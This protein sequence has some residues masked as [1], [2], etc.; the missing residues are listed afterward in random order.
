MPST[1]II[2]PGF[3][4]RERPIENSSVVSENGLVT[5]TAVFLGNSVQTD[6]FSNPVI[7]SDPIDFS[8]I[9]RPL[10]LARPAANTTDD[11]FFKVNSPI[12]QNYFSSLAGIPLQGLFIE[13][14]TTEKRDGLLYYR[15]SA[16]GAANPPTL[17][18][19]K[20]VSPRSFS[21]SA[22]NRENET[23]T[24]A[25]DY[26]SE[27]ITVST[28][29]V[30]DGEIP[31]P[32]QFPRALE[33]WNIRGDGTIRRRGVTGAALGSEFVGANIQAYPRVLKSTSTTFR[34]GVVQSTKAFQFVYE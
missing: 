6:S 2:R 13:N 7:F 14:I 28:Y 12:N 4:P 27:T 17:T 26:L 19:Q 3:D 30:V 20:D 9:P 31:I 1:I 16:V 33:T 11:N 10:P 23:L 18:I 5:A 15:I 25:F 24:F 21:K 8:S 29:H 32:D 22:T 34:N